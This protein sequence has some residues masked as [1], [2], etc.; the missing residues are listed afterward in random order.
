MLTLFCTPHRSSLRAHTAEAQ[1]LFVMLKMIPP[2]DVAPA[3]PPLALAFVIDTSGSMHEPARATPKGQ[4]ALP[5]EQKLAQAIAMAHRL[6]DDTRLRPEDQVALI[7]FDDQAS[8]LLP[9]TPLADKAAI[10]HALDTLAQYSGGT[11]MARGLHCVQEALAVLAPEVSQRVWLLTDGQT[12]DEADCRALATQLAAHNTP[13]IPLGLGET[14][15]EILL[16]D[17]AEVTQGRPYHVQDVAQLEAILDAELGS[18]VREVVTNVQASVATARGVT[19][20]AITRIYPSLAAVS[21]EAAP[22]R[23]GNVLAGDYTVVLLEFTVSGLTRPPSQVRL[24]QVGVSANVPGLGQHVE[25]LPHD[26]RV[27]FTT[28]EAAMA[29]VDQEVMGYVR[30]KNLDHLMQQ[31][32]Q[33]AP[34]D[35]TQARQTLQVAMSLTQSLGNAVVTQM[36]HQALDELQ[37]TGTLTAQTRKTMALGGRTQTLQLGATMPMQGVPSEEDIRRVSGT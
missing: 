29:V 11:Q 1:K 17:L 4:E 18:A 12:A 8:T 5:S 10:H 31:A 25:L 2:P 14:Y 16:R 32:V 30:Q 15:N 34:G 36:L 33:Q 28:D 7:H 26:L 24:A 9:L 3:R 20:E 23:L 22:Y 19:L 37:R 6:L 21:L 35:P 27:T 13:L